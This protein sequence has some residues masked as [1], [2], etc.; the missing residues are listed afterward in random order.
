MEVYKKQKIAYS[1]LLVALI[2]F[3]VSYFGD[4]FGR[5]LASTF[6][7]EETPSVQQQTE[8]EKAEK[9][10]V[11]EEKTDDTPVEEE[12][13]TEETDLPASAMIEGVP[14]TSQ[15]PFGNW[16][17]PL[18]QH[19]CEE[20]SLLM[21]HYW[22]QGK[23]FTKEKALEEILAMSKFEEE[24]Y[25]KEM[26]DMSLADTLKLW[27][28]YFGYKKSFTKYDISVLDIKKEL[29]AGHPVVLPMDGTK[30][31]NPY[32]TPPG[33]LYHELIVIGYDDA[34]QKFITNDP[35]TRFGEGY[36]YDYDVFMNSIRDYK[37]GFNE[38]V[39]KV[40][41]AMLVIEKE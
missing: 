26:Y 20:A 19:G 1:L 27:R 33:P 36:D 11:T 6:K 23:T 34:K 9:T 12:K 10:P 28:E 30:L 3:T 38:P 31:G 40:V 39:D 8:D 35:G 7:I 16:A 32:Y 14:F 41:R 15:A 17:D 25:G 18:E 22:I 21:A 37:T 24:K 13:P 29:A 5:Y 4:K 2:L